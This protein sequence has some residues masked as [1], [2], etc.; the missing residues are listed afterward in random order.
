MSYESTVTSRGQVTIPKA[1]RERMNLE[2]GETVLFRFD[3]EGDVRIVRVPSDPWE[4]LTEARERGSSAD[5]DATEVLDAE[6]E[7]WE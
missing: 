2:P 4:R 3:E 6:R 7:Q 1:V 5:V